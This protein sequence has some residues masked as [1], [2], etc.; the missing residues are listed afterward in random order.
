MKTQYFLTE[1]RDKANV[2][3]KKTFWMFFF[4]SNI[5]FCVLRLSQNENAFVNPINQVKNFV[6]DS[7]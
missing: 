3:L 7:I 5:L 4:K 1:E 6:Q 2:R